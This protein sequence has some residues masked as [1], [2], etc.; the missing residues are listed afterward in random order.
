M[1]T[2]GTEIWHPD[3]GHNLD[4]LA[5]SI[6]HEM[7]KNVY[8]PEVLDVIEVN[9]DSLSDELRALS[10]DIHGKS[11]ISRFLGLRLKLIP[12][13]TPSLS[14]KKSAKRFFLFSDDL[15]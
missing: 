12:Q 6:R 8:K 13:I 10:L 1:T 9:I 4:M 3:D 7:G 2:A 11:S 5:N 14:M 15:S